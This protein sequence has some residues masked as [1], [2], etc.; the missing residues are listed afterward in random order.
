MFH[1]ER[2]L[3]FVYEL[4]YTDCLGCLTNGGTTWSNLYTVPADSVSGHYV[5]PD[6]RTRPCR[7]YRLRVTP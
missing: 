3:R 1:L 5:I 7:L 2:V 4:Q 6:T